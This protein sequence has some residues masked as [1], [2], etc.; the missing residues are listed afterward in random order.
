MKANP[1][2]L[3]N[4]SLDVVMNAIQPDIETLKQW[5]EKFKETGSVGDLPR[6]WASI[7]G[8]LSIF[9]DGPRRANPPSREARPRIHIRRLLI[10]VQFELPGRVRKRGR[11]R[12]RDVDLIR[13]SGSATYLS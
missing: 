13:R 4:G 6:R 2:F 7:T 8:P 12:V 3:F 1:S 5:H 10:H 11:P 9:S